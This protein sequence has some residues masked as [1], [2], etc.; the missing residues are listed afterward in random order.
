LQE[1]FVGRFSDHHA[2]LLGKMIA[3]VEAIEADIAEIG[4]ENV[5]TSANSKPSATAS[6]STSPHNLRFNQ[7]P[8]PRRF[9]TRDADA[10]LVTVDFRARWAHRRL[11]R[12]APMHAE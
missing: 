1:A 2:F 10:R 11:R 6:P 8:I 5:T 9:A 3:W 12:P 7:R 4:V